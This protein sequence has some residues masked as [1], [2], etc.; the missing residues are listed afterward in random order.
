MGSSESNEKWN[1]GPHS[2]PGKDLIILSGSW[3]YTMYV[4][5]AIYRAHVQAHLASM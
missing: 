5:L 2:A 3:K 4:V 1:V